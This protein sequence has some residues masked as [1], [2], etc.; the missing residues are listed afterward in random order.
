MALWRVEN[1]VF[2]KSEIRPGCQN[3]F[4]LLNVTKQ[5]RRYDNA[6][7]E[8]VDTSHGWMSGSSLASCDLGRAYINGQSAA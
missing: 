2:F 5:F 8:H 1:K 7:I 3:L 6:V 4:L